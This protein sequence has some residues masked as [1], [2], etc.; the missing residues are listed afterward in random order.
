MGIL[1]AENVFRPDILE[2]CTVIGELSLDG[3]VREIKGVLPIATDLLKRDHKRLIVPEANVY[4]AAVVSGLEVYPVK[5][6]AECV[7]FLKGE[8]KIMPYSV[9]VESIFDQQYENTSVDFSDVKGQMSARRAVEIAVA[10]GHNLLMVGSPGSGKSMLAKRIPTIIP[11]MTLEESLEVSKIHSIVYGLSNQKNGLIGIRPFRSPHHTISN[12]ALIGGGS[13]PKPGEVSLSHNGVLFLDEF[14][15]FRRDVL[16]VLREPLEEGLVSI[17]RA[18]GRVTFPANF[19]LVAAMNPCPCGYL[20]DPK[21]ECRCS[22]IQ[23]HRYRSKISGPLLDRI[24]IHVDVPSVKYDEFKSKSL[25]E[26]SKT[27][28]TRVE[29]ARNIQRKRFKG[30]KVFNNADMSTRHLKK[31]CEIDQECEKLLKSAF[32]DL[33]ISARAHDRILKVART[34]ADL[35]E[36]ENI[37]AVHIGEAINY[38]SFDKSYI[39]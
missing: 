14:P 38:R 36:Q 23:I 29:N 30:L 32:D 8:T 7:S 34:I 28:R 37:Q 11:K 27:I 31:F 10:G 18:S 1:A 24:D 25:G 6:L 33:N 5:T 16:E 21:K 19:M 15:E 3:S 2:R 12:T 17:S 4:E 20:S 22:P 35:G 13:D 9:D 39:D 26:D